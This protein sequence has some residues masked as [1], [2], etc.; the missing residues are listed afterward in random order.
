MNFKIIWRYH[1]NR[2]SPSESH[3]TKILSWL[4]ICSQ[5]F[6]ILII[7]DLNCMHF[8]NFDQFYWNQAIKIN[9]I[10]CTYTY[11]LL[12]VMIHSQN[13]DS[14]FF[15][16]LQAFSLIFKIERIEAWT[17]WIIIWRI[18]GGS[19]NTLLSINQNKNGFFVK[20]GTSN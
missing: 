7:F 3:Q 5:N 13:L 10:K 8:Y 19:K 12:K 18:N 4:R 16:K 17:E 2:L 11:I 6:S 15:F 14:T 1:P 9:R 20:T